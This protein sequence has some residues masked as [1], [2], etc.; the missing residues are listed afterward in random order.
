[1]SYIKERFLRLNW[2]K[3]FI[4]IFFLL[5]SLFFGYS[6]SRYV[7][8]IIDNH[9]LEANHFYFNSDKLSDT[10]VNY[11][12]NNWSGADTFP[13]NIELNSKKNELE[14]SPSDISYDVRYVC[15]S[16]V[17]CSLTKN[18]GTIFA[19][20]HSDSFSLNVTPVRPFKTG[21]S[22][23][24]DIYATST[25]PYVKEIS[26]R[27]IITVGQEGVNY[28]IIDEVNSA[29]FNLDISNTVSTYKIT[30]AFGSYSVG[31]EISYDTYQTLSSSNK[32]KCVSKIIELSFDP[33]VILLDTTNEIVS[34]AIDS[35]TV[36]IGG[37]DYINNISF[38]VD[39]SSSYAIRFYKKN[40]TNDYS[41][42][43]VN[44]SSIVDVE[45]R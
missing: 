30:E 44:D 14:F 45:V 34:R 5:F 31:D 26:A 23:I 1:M 43:I 41:Y 16:D 29:Y 2:F 10:Q 18:F 3:R 25:S 20:S 39:A 27:F 7:K 24:V 33:N 40:K 6:F 17:V 12:I 19:T 37:Y 15:D 35:D 21:D 9:F 38:K 42:P 11:R 13:I 4:L 28:E 36:S 8:E 32:N 22:T